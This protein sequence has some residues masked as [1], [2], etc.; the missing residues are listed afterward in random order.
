MKVRFSVIVV[1]KFSVRFMVRFRLRLISFM[2][3]A[4]LMLSFRV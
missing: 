3:R 1:V 2:I 4:R